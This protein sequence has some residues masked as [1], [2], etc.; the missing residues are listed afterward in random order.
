L[1]HSGYNSGVPR[2]LEETLEHALRETPPT[3]LRL[4]YAAGGRRL[5][6][7]VLRV[8]AA[9][10][11]LG[12]ATGAVYFRKP[13][14]AQTQLLYWQQ[15]CMNYE[16]PPDHIAYLQVGGEAPATDKAELAALTRHDGYARHGPATVRFNPNC[17]DHFD[18][19][20]GPAF[21]YA[22]PLKHGEAC[23]FLHQCRSPLGHERLVGV[24]FQI[25]ALTSHGMLEVY[26][27]FGV[28]IRPATVFTKPEP[29]L[30][31]VA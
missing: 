26:E 7:W 22:F 2:S 19:S 6:R 10:V 8:L 29:I 17:L 3:P 25:D 31:T 12:T 9:L 11:V 28:T 15:Q 13:I 21:T 16:E 18:Q 24:F 20:S 1:K 4:H 23:L 27:L 5:R 14:W 30:L